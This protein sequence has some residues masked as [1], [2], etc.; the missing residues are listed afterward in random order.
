MDLVVAPTLPNVAANVGQVLFEVGEPEPVINSY[1]R[2]SAP[3]NLTGLPA[4]SVPCGFSDGGLPIGMQL[5]GKPFAESTVLQA[6]AA[7]E[8]VNERAG[9][10]PRIGAAGG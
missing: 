7:Y 10:V 4:A 8:R 5:I 1:V 6:A 3:G 9:E 2:A